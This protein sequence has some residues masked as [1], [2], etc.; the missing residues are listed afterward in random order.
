M[1]K[2]KLKTTAIKA[3]FEEPR[4]K[5]VLPKH[6]VKTSAIKDLLFG[7]RTRRGK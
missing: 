7:D 3:L 2:K 4:V 5:I 6:K 1:A